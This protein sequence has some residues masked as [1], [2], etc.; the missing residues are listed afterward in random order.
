MRRKNIIKNISTSLFLQ[1]LTIIC[2]FIVPKLIIEAYG[3]DT[4]GL[5]SSITKFLGYIVLLES[6]FGPV[7][8]SLLYKPIAKK[9]KQELESVLKSSELFFRKVAA[10]FIVYI[11][12]LCFV[13]PLFINKEFDALFTISL[14]II[15]SISTFSEYFFGITYKLYLQSEQKS[16][17][18]SYIEIIATILHAI[19]VVILVY[20]KCDVRIVKF[21]TVIIFLMRPIFQNLY[22][23]RKYNIDLKHV[24]ETKKIEQKWDGMAHHIASVIHENTDVAVITIFMNLKEVSV[25]SIY[26]L[27]VG[28]IRS[29]SQSFSSGVDASWGDMIARKEHDNLNIKFNRYKSLY[30]I[31]TA[32][33]FICTFI[34][35]IPF[36]KVYTKDFT[37]YN[38]IRP[39]F[40]Y[41]LVLAEFIWIVR[42][43]YNDLIKAAGHFKQTK[44][45]AILEAII[46]ILLSI[47]LV[48]KFGL[49]GVAIGTFVAMTFRM[50][51]FI[52]YSSKNILK[53]SLLKQYNRLF[54]I[55]YF[56]CRFVNKVTFDSF[57]IWIKYAF[58]VFGITS[59]VVLIINLIFNNKE[60]KNIFVDLKSR[61]LLKK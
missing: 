58:I 56:I 23:K 60:M 43:P 10:I 27:V 50:I 15:I 36:V 29:L 32:I 5:I 38:Y 28:G 21:A 8:K 1:V 48:N 52:N 22:V 35:I 41:I 37:D 12:I 25:Y 57:I 30:D 19:V 31:I 18:T 54:I 13:Y 11:I 6:G 39:L 26:F 4:N 44:K 40:G 55:I 46:N 17:I 45:G 53:S 47:I 51:Y 3:S 49:V 24:K 9:D 59:I 20:L 7:V 16:Y 2:G 61:F 33:I 34:L 14:I 42:Q